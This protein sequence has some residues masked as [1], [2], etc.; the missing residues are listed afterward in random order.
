M[1]VCASCLALSS[2]LFYDGV[3][4]SCVLVIYGSE[5]R[6]YIGLFVLFL[7]RF[8]IWR[9]CD[10]RCC[11]LSNLRASTVPARTFESQLPGPARGDAR[12][13][14]VQERRPPQPFG[15]LCDPRFH[16][17]GRGSVREGAA[18]SAVSV[19]GVCMNVFLSRC[20]VQ[21]N[22]GGNILSRSLH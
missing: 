10:L 2:S 16:P 4:G 9:F 22:T 18:R 19:G 5:I 21:I 8:S 1:L 14:V 6:C 15:R 12:S 13:L 20:G 3:P 11:S 17:A 7:Q